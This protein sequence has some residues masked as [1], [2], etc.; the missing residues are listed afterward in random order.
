LGRLSRSIRSIE[1][2]LFAK[3]ITQMDQKLR[4]ESIKS[5]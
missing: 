1:R 4:N 3:I 2:R 5:N